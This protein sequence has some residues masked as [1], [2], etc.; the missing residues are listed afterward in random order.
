MMASKVRDRLDELIN[1]FGDFPAKIPDQLE[2][3]WR[4]D[5]TDV[6]IELDHDVITILSEED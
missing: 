3:S 4:R 1:E 6:S 5:I 2:A